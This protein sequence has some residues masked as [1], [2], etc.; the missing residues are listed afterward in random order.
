MEQKICFE[1]MAAIMREP[2]HARAIAKKLGTNHMAI[3]R[4]LK[5]LVAENVVDF[6]TEGKNKVYFPKKGLEARNFAIMAEFYKLNKT[7]EKY[8]E[9][10]AITEDI[11]KNPKI[12]L[13]MLF[14]SYAKGIARKDSDIDVFIETENR[15]LKQEIEL[16]NSKLS[17]KIGSYDGDNLLI[18]EIEKNHVIIKGAET[19]Y[20][21][22]RFFH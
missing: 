10:R 3:V 20:E 11:Q 5:A 17:V 22:I 2:M 18:K 13:A 9:L 4:G 15:K 14:G 12:E 8:P 21:R 1:I 19:Y 7:L 6:R 16:M